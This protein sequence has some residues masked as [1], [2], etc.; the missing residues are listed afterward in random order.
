[1]ASKQRNLP[2]ERWLK[3][4]VSASQNETANLIEHIE[5]KIKNLDQDIIGGVDER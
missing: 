1:M 2:V 4:P 5:K 3:H